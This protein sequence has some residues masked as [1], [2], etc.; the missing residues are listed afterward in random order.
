MKKFWISVLSFVFVLSLFQVPPTKAATVSYVDVEVYADIYG[1]S[2]YGLK[3]FIVNRGNRLLIVKSA[4]IKISDANNNIMLNKSYSFGEIELSPG[5]YH[6]FDLKAPELQDRQ[7]EMAKLEYRVNHI[8]G[9]TPINKSGT[10][11]YVNGK[12]ISPDVA[13]AIINS[14]VLVPMRSIFEALG[15]TVNWDSTTNMITS[16]KEDIDVTI[17]HKIGQNYMLVNGQKVT[18]DVSS[19]SIKGRTMVPVRAIANAFFVNV[20]YVQQDKVNYITVMDLYS[21]AR[22]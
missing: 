17:K 20:E 7:F 2:E 18:L 19:Q 13:P 5:E 14:R 16:Y 15:A 1:N 11:V 3:W 9:I 22:K 6:Y 12:K 4:D 10:F 8:Q 21:L